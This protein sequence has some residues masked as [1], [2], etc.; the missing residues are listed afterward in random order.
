LKR[1][2]EQFSLGITDKQQCQIKLFIAQIKG[3]KSGYPFVV[4]LESLAF[5]SGQPSM[6]VEGH[7][8]RIITIQ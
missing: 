2:A 5:L 7:K 8:I 4:C 1:F 6:A 3:L